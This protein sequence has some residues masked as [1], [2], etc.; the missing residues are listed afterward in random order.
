MN[1]QGESPNRDD[2]VR[3]HQLCMDLHNFMMLINS[4]HDVEEILHKIVEESCKIL[5]CESA[6][7]AMREGEKWV[8]R[9]VNKLPDDLIG[10]AFTDEELPTAALAMIT[11]KPVAIDDAYH[12]DRANNEL[13]KSLGTKSVMILPLM[14]KGVVTGTLLCGYHSA[15]VSFT[16]TEIDYAGR[17]SA[18]V[19]IAL[20]NA[21]LYQDLQRTGADMEEAKKLGDA[22]NEIDAILYSTEDYDAIMKRILQLATDA[23]GA[24]TAM[25]FSKEGDRW[26]TRYVYKLSQTLIGRSFSNS[27]VLH[28]AI[29]AETRRSIVVLDALHSQ[30][31]GPEFV[32]RLGI[33]SLLDFPLIVKGEIIG[34]LAFH[35]HSSPV[36]FNVRQ[37]EFV[38]KLQNSISLALA[39]VERAG[40]LEEASRELEA[41]NYTVAH[42]LRKPLTIING[43]CQAIK[44]LCGD[45]LN[46][47]CNDYLHETYT[48]TLRMNRLIDALLNF[49]RLARVELRRETV[50]LSAIAKEVAAELKQAEPERQVT[51]RIAEAVSAEGDENL[52][53]VVLDN[54]LGN[55]WK[56][57]GTQEETIIEFGAMEID[58]KQAYFVRDNGTGFD[59]ADADKLFTPFQRL[60]GADKFR[61]FGIGLATVERII[62]RHGGRIWAEGE[63]GKGATFYFTLPADKVS[64]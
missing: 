51:F 41:F 9:Y 17:V 25:I 38:R 28:A 45:K 32:R 1:G 27:E 60:P 5:G 7:I 36:P 13:M 58:G 42:D 61:G 10:R 55:A 11:K 37:V 48:G 22:L 46:E 50:D 3:A 8:I 40:K 30:D 31:V 53:R 23:I 54:L 64:T 35:Y 33:L 56:Y 2:V 57:T 15:A 24:E 43:Y 14:E 47:Q 4:I 29:T 19:A 6:Q 63:P 12:D 52:L 44:E 20:Q 26:V 21:H 49:S 34:N 59:M 18:G 62:R 16:D 39:L